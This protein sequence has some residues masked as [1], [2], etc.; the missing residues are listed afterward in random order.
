MK[1]LSAQQIRQAD[2]HTISH[3]PIRS[4]DLMERAAAV[5]A[6][7][8]QQYSPAGTPIIIICGK[9]NNGGDGLAIARL[10]SAT[11]YQVQ[12]CILDY[13]PHES[14]DFTANLERLTDQAAAAIWRIATASDIVLPAG[15]IVIDAILGTGINKPAEGLIADTIRRIN[16]SGLR[17]ISIDVPSGLRTDEPTSAKDAVVRAW[18]TLTFQQPKLAF[19]FP[20]SGEYTGEFDVLDIRIDTSFIPEST[21]TYFYVSA[22]TLQ[23]LL[24]TR[25]KFSH[26]GT[27]GH[28]L[29]IAGAYGKMGA[30]V[31]AASACL[32]S[33]AG[34]LT[35]HIPAC[36]YQ[37]IQTSLPEAMVSIDAGQDQVTTAPAMDLYNAV[38]IGPGIGTADATARLLKQ[39]IQS[40][41]GSLVIDAD[42]LNILARQRT[43]LEFLPPLTI[44][45]PHPKEFDRL[46]QKHDSSWQRLDTAQQL[47]KK[48]NLVIV[49]KGA[50]TA[51]VLPDGSVWFN[52]TGNP[53]L[54]KGG[55]GDILTGIVTG[56]LARGYA[57]AVAACLGVYLH[58]LAADMAV[59]SIHAESLLASDVIAHISAAFQQMYGTKAS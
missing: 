42:A 54:A 53:A 26:K 19:M 22:S 50:H 52:S 10:L 59:R 58:G 3:E 16:D 23:P 49:L 28:A 38:G 30:A 43:W 8:I 14:E 15:S 27:Y 29:L 13:T 55:S 1:I 12:V 32:R 24:K 20:E 37:I 35:A 2:Q 47:A 5:C 48:N 31:L 41:S 9:G 39:V 33:G 25:S 11:G 7:R 40:V 4:I 44:L 56:L 51:T 21:C 18:R 17:I 6:A 45:T 36:G 34:L 57:P 46:T